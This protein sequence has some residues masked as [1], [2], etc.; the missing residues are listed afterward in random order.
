MPT[1]FNDLYQK[2]IINQLIADAMKLKLH[3][4]M[5]HQVPLFSVIDV[6]R[7]YIS[8]EIIPQFF[9]SL[10]SLGVQWLGL[11]VVVKPEFYWYGELACRNLPASFISK[12]DV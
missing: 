4:F 7:S 5:L 1:K 10:G 8:V 9:S 2:P 11:T 6:F 12:L 3:F